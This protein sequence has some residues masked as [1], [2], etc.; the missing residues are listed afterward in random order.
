MR[1]IVHGKPTLA[2]PGQGWMA[3][4]AEWNCVHWSPA[5]SLTHQ[6]QG[7]Q[8]LLIVWGTADL[9]RS[10]S[11][12]L[13]SWLN[14]Q[15]S[16]KGRVEASPQ[17]PT[18]ESSRSTQ[19]HTSDNSYIQNPRSTHLSPP[20]L[21]TWEL[22]RETHHPCRWLF[23]HCFFIMSFLDAQTQNHLEVLPECIWVS[24]SG[25]TGVLP[26]IVRMLQETF[27]TY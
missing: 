11:G 16:P 25:H 3:C 8:Y 9:S 20:W 1:R 17:F 27:V 18:A 10:C 12:M 7:W 21:A 24:M 5:T 13:A 2:E 15:S 4:L 14:E 26:S 19:L 6:L 22:R 23:L